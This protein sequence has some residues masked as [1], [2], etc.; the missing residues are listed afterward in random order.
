M[1][2]FNSQFINWE[3]TKRKHKRIKTCLLLKSRLGIIYKSILYKKYRDW[4]F[5][6]LTDIKWYKEKL[7]QLGFCK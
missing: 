2:I 5:R 6:R 7:I 3:R 1:S 4:L